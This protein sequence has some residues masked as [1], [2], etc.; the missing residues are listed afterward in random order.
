[1]FQDLFY[2]TL[3]LCKQA[4]PTRKFRFKNKLLSM[5]A[6]TISLCLSMFPWAKF[7]RTKGAVK[8]HLL[9]DHDGY[10]PTYAY[11]ENA[12]KHDVTIARKMPLAPGS[13]IA[14]DR[15]Y[16]DYKLY[17]QW[18]ENDIYFVTRLKDNADYMLLEV[19]EVP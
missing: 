2:E 9:L 6:T 14:M 5:D 8:L 12:K 7:R 11:I 3:G 10:L 17:A 13:I 16:N 19:L 18:T 4:A 1:M 15:A